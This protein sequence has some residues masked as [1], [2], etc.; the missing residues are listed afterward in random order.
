[1]KFKHPGPLSWQEQKTLQAENRLDW[2][3]ALIRQFQID[4]A[5]EQ[6]IVD[7]KYHKLFDEAEHWARQLKEKRHFSKA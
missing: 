4:F 5:Y 3:L 1:M 7:R 6:R 2:Y